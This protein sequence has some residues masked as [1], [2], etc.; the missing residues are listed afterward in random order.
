MAL[1]FLAMSQAHVEDSITR[2]EME[3]CMPR[4][5]LICLFMASSFLSLF[6]KWLFAWPFTTLL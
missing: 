6:N 4:L 1:V 2:K 3:K 5:S